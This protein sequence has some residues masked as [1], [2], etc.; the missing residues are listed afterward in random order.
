MY[1]YM[2]IYIYI[3]IYIYTYIYIYIYIYIPSFDTWILIFGN[4]LSQFGVYH[5]HKFHKKPTSNQPR[6]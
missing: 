2:Y 5:S 6:S 3:Y 4:T 1:I